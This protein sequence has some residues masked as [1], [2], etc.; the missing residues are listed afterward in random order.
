MAIDG[1]ESAGFLTEKQ[2]RDIFSTMPL[3]FSD[4]KERIT[5][6][7]RGEMP[8]PNTT[9]QRRPLSEFYIVP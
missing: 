3:G 5:H 4:G 1:I 6:A 2:R 7:C 8:P 9:F